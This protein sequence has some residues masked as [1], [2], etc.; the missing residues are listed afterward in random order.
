M[1][2]STT[3]DGLKDTGFWQSIYWINLLALLQPLWGSD[4]VKAENLLAP[5]YDIYLK[6][7]LLVAPFLYLAIYLAVMWATKIATSAGVRSVKVLALD[8]AFSVIPIAVVYNFAHY[9]AVLLYIWTPLPYILSDPFAKGWNLLGLTLTT[10]QPPVDMGGIWNTEVLVILAGHLAS[11][12]LAHAI[13]VRVFPL[14][15]LALRGEIPLL[16]LMV[17][18]TFFGLFVL[19]LPLAIH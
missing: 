10:E 8:F 14:Q 15:R 13:A 11:V 5:A 9:Y 4:L 16:V 17:A 18:Y 1:L 6:A 2:S 19:S 12:Y 3:Y 7:G